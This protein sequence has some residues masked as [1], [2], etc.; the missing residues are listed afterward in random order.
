MHVVCAWCKKEFPEKAPYD[1]PSISHT[2]CRDCSIKYWGI[3]PEE[4][5]L[6]SLR[7][8]EM[9]NPNVP[10]WKR[11]L[12][13]KAKWLYLSGSGYTFHEVVDYLKNQ[14]K[15]LSEKSITS[16]V[17][18]ARRQLKKRLKK[19]PRALY[20]DLVEF[21]KGLKANGIEAVLATI[22]L[23]KKFE[24]A[25]PD[26][27]NKAIKE[28]YKLKKNPYSSRAKYCHERIKTPKKFDPRSYRT[29]TLGKGIKATFGC[30]KGSY[31]PRKGRCKTA[32]QMQR[33]LIPVGA[34]GCK[35]GGKAI[36]HNPTL[37]VYDVYWVDTKG[38]HIFTSMRAVNSEEAHL[39]LLDRKGDKVDYVMGV[40]LQRKSKPKSRR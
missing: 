4:V 13:S 15:D 20:D 10:M 27:I 6:K 40:Q 7:S 33:R 38:A 1:D 39:K 34:K 9:P 24:F 16:A 12:I 37:K 26:E 8:K 28:V 14:H 25:H 3:D 32:M 31:S 36:R 18:I 2:I 30:P 23:Y 22:S 35:V 21:A 11:D 5:K 17:E 19:N 29:K